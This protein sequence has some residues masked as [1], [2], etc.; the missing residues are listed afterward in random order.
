RAVRQNLSLIV[1]EG[2]GG[3]ADEIAAAW[4]ARPA[5][6]DDPVMA[7]IIDDGEIHLH[8]L[9]NPVKGV[10][11]LIIRELGVDRVLMQAWEVFAD[12]D[13]SAKKQQKRFKWL[14]L[15]ILALGVAGTALAIIQQ[16]YAPRDN[17]EAHNLLPASL[18][19]NAEGHWIIA[20]HVPFHWWLI[21]Q[22]LIIIP[23]LVTVLIA[24][25][26]R[27]KQANKWL[28]LRAGA[29][30][31]KREIYRYRTRAMD[32]KQEPEQQL[33]Q[34]VEDVTRR[35]MRTEVN[36]SA[37]MPYKKDDKKD[38]GIPPPMYAY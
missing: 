8:L 7:E 2:S 30:A 31:I 16:V 20:D 33:A 36:L 14:Q 18:V 15:A 38:V 12:Y 19:T 26:N 29:E 25:A 6:P 22:A 4:K 23:I 1:V 34:R 17:T 3:L 13:L 35:T 32:Y 37:I 9:S 5:L 21:H 11:R 10:E 27:F 24:A 28:L